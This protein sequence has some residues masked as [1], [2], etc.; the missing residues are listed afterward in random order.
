MIAYYYTISAVGYLVD[1][2]KKI[3]IGTHVMIDDNT[4]Y[5]RPKLQKV[6]RMLKMKFYVLSFLFLTFLSSWFIKK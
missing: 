5:F 4:D 3:K 6:E 2:K 1:T